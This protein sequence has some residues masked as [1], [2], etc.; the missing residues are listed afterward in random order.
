MVDAAVLL[1]NQFPSA[2]PRPPVS[3]EHIR[4]LDG[5]PRAA[6]ML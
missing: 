3:G 2:V 6:D 5:V 1:T 4:Q